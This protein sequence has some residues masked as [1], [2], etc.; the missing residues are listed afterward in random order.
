MKF[1]TIKD[2]IGHIFIIT[3]SIFLSLHNAFAAALNDDIYTSKDE[4][5][6]VTVPPLNTVGVAKEGTTR[7]LNYATFTSGR[8]YY[9]MMDGEYHIDRFRGRFMDTQDLVRNLYKALPVAM[10]GIL[11]KEKNA[12]LKM[13]SCKFLRTTSP[14]IYQCVGTAIVQDIP[15]VYV[16]TSVINQGYMVNIYGLEPTWHG[17]SFHWARYKNTI[18]SIIVHTREHGRIRMTEEL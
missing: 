2:H 5:L 16:G 12:K 9:W 1:I 7:D 15:A 6:T 14:Y 3:A 10:R 4:Q 13:K 11:L 17:M 18:D 8:G